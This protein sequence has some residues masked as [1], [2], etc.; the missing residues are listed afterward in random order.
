MYGTAWS[1]IWFGG[2]NLLNWERKYKKYTNEIF[3]S[4][5]K[6]FH[7]WNGLCHTALK[8]AK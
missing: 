3:F 4:L 5:K 6:S 1:E 2:G 8:T 7:I